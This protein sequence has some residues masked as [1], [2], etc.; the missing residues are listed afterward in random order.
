[1]NTPKI[2]S[3][4]FLI[5]AFS[6]QGLSQGKLEKKNDPEK[7][8]EKP[9]GD[10]PSD[11]SMLLTGRNEDIQ[12][13]KQYQN[14]FGE[15]VKKGK[16]ETTARLQN[17]ILRIFQNEITRSNRNV[18][19]LKSGD[20]EKLETW[21]EKNKPGTPINTD[22]EIQ[23]L[24]SRINYEKS[25]YQIFSDVDVKTLKDDR[26]LTT[27]V[28]YVNGFRRAMI[29]STKYGSED[30]SVLTNN[31]G[32]SKVVSGETGFITKEGSSDKIKSDDPRIASWTGSAETRATKFGE[33]QAA[34]QKSLQGTDDRAAKKNYRNIIGLMQ[35][36]FN[37]NNWML[38]MLNSGTID[39]SAVDATQLGAKINK[40]QS[41]LNKAQAFLFSTPEDIKTNK[42]EVLDIIGQFGNSLK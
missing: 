15:S 9:A 6:L 34:L 13:L 39:K 30:N 12:R 16:T 7:K 8:Q 23:I 40:Q 14:L 37:S 17:E 29:R 5:V 27:V 24:S 35:D 26:Y 11:E 3:L 41:L 38:S 33:E 22:L 18:E 2:F 1:M 28:G 19:Q 36:E 25:V 20:I 21:Q 4:L 42:T 32:G 10:I 31:T